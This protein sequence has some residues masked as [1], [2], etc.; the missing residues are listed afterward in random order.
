MQQLVELLKMPTCIGGV[1][2]VVLAHLG[3]PYRRTFADP[4]DYVRFAQEHKLDLDF[5]TPPQRV[6]TAAPSS[7]RR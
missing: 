2:R 1:R 5:T 6:S 7:T 4:W 3:N